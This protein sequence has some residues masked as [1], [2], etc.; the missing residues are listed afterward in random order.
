MMKMSARIIALLLPVVMV[1]SGCAAARPCEDILEV[2]RQEQQCLELARIMKNNQY[3]QQA[4]TAKK[5]YENECENLRYYRDGYDT[6]CK[7]QHKPIGVREG[8]PE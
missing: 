8:G 1:L 7:G 5:R 4:I 2:N 6:I 3:L